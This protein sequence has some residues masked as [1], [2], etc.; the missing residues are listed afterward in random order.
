MISASAIGKTPLAGTPVDHD[1]RRELESQLPDGDEPRTTTNQLSRC[2]DKNNRRLSI[3]I[4]ASSCIE[5]LL[6]APAGE[7]ASFSITALRRAYQ[8]LRIAM[9]ASL[10]A[11]RRRVVQYGRHKKPER[12]EAAPVA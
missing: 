2:R 10:T 3:P 5:L 6:N 9:R 4:G 8:P 12:P 1:Q 11:A 7:Y